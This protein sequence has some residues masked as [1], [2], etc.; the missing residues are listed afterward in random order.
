MIHKQPRQTSKGQ[1][2]SRT[3]ARPTEPITH[4]VGVTHLPP[5][6]QRCVSD[7]LVHLKQGRQ[8][9]TQSKWPT[10]V[11]GMDNNLHHFVPQFYLNRFVDPDGLL[12]V[13]D[14][15]TDRIF[16]ANPKNLAAERGFYT[17]PEGFPDPTVMEQQFSALEQEA[18]LIS[19]DWLARMTLGASI[20]IQDVNRKIMSLYITTQLLRTSEARTMLIQGLIDPETPPV[21]QSIQ[22]NLHTALLW[23]D[24]VVSEI[25][26][27]VRNGTWTFRINETSDS[28][29]T[30][31]DPFKVRSKTQHL[32]WAQTSLVGAYL[33]IPL[34]PRVLMY[35]F[36]SRGWNK[37][38][39][40]DGRVIPVPLEPELVK[41][42]NVHQVGHSRRF[43]FASGNDFR[44]A[45]EFASREP[46]IVGQW[47][48]RFNPK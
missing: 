19:E 38:R 25:S 27:W 1:T 28:L 13:Y 23:N 10:G 36:D 21:E 16:S 7:Y 35:C 45:R 3:Y 39:P 48:Q 5:A 40:F 12:W 9:P 31:G 42:A 46:R 18:A 20:E 30:S 32:H 4:S 6:T 34:T 15:D 2:P 41:D 22:R 44:L 8:R 33:L 24:D 43:V 29:Y 37:L 11:F 17:L 14:K 47:R 26:K